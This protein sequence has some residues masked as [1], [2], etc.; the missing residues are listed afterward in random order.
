MAELRRTLA[1]LARLPAEEARRKLPGLVRGM[2]NLK[3]SDSMMFEA[4]SYVL[5]AKVALEV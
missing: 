3:S 1:E 5:V 2:A 4:D